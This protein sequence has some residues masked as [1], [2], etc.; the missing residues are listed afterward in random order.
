[1]TLEEYL[2]YKQELLRL[3]SRI[4]A[5][6]RKEVRLLFYP[7]YC[8]KLPFEVYSEL[9]PLDEGFTPGGGEDTDYCI[10]AALKDIPIK[11]ISTSFVLHFNGCSTWKVESK[12]E[13]SR[14][15]QSFRSHF[16]KKWGSLLLRLENG[17]RIDLSD[18]IN[19]S[20]QPGVKIRSLLRK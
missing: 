4:H 5:G 2:Q 17:D 16:E 12:E 13:E 15:V 10:R 8:I 20:S 14:R 9:G 7:F 11:A 3:N 6:Q 18:D 1:M 19:G